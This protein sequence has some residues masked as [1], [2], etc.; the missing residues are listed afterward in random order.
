MPSRSAP[1][2]SG[3]PVGIKNHL[4]CLT[5]YNISERKKLTI[6]W[7][8]FFMQ[9]SPALRILLGGCFKLFVVWPVFLSSH[10]EAEPR[11]SLP[12]WIFSLPISRF[13]CL[14]VSFSVRWENDGLL[15]QMEHDLK[16]EFTMHLK[17]EN[18]QKNDVFIVF[19]KFIFPVIHKQFSLS[20]VFFSPHTFS[21]DMF[22]P[23]FYF[24]KLNQNSSQFVGFWNKQC[25]FPLKKINENRR[26]MWLY[27]FAMWSR[28][29]A[30]FAKMAV[31]G[32]AFMQFKD[33]C[34]SLGDLT[35]SLWIAS[36]AI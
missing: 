12:L 9:F 19:F 32:K 29:F 24:S 26:N 18:V 7:P 1:D 14:G 4:F 20:F 6:S 17:F 3:G 2:L 33:I 34:V 30:T 16:F 28:F 21:F 23:T 31:V 22:P 11:F 35:P 25:C 5:T 13:F 27:L 15:P 36:P 8:H 10:E